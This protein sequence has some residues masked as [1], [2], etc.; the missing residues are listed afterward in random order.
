[1]K[2]TL[3]S[4]EY[5]TLLGYLKIARAEAGITQ[6]QLAGSLNVTQSFISKCERG[7]RRM[8][9]V[10]L[11]AWCRALSISFSE[12]VLRL[13]HEAEQEVSRDWAD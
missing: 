9:V 10:E 13:D 1:M 6:E 12:L 5:R 8:D 3:F 4:E 11:R 2:K 7:E